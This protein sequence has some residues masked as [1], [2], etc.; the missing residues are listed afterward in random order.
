MDMKLGR[1]GVPR[2]LLLLL[3]VSCTDSFALGMRNCPVNQPMNQP[4]SP[5]GRAKHITHV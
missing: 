1:Q 3:Q 5:C 4:S 2:L